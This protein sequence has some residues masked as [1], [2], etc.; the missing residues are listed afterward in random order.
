MDGSPRA[1]LLSAWDLFP[2]ASL[3]AVWL[4]LRHWLPLLPDRIPSHWNAAG[5]VNGWM[6]KRAFLA[7]AAWPGLGIWALLFLI[8][9]A[10]RLDEAPRG[11]FGAKAL[12]PLRGLFPTGFILM[13]GAFAPMSA[14]YGGR[15]I[16]W[17]VGL[18]V[19]SLIAGLVPAIRLARLAPP[20]PGA[21]PSDYRWGGLIYWKAGDPR[22]LVP[23]RLGLGW[24]FNFGR[25]AAWLLLA[26]MLA[27]IAVALVVL[28]RR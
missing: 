11:Q 17:G 14:I 12:L 20:I 7:F 21:T 9:A 10:M 18:M 8:G 5:L 15:A 19:I 13:A 6:D 2:A 25:P 26:L 16:A 22:L 3:G 24:T 4:W 28:A 27:P 23:K 1:P